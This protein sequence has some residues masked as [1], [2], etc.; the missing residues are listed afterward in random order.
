MISNQS[1]SSNYHRR[2]I[3]HIFCSDTK[4]TR[5]KVAVVGSEVC[6]FVFVSYLGACRDAR[7]W[8]P[9]GMW[10]AKL[11]CACTRHRSLAC[12]TINWNI[13]RQHFIV[14]DA[15]FFFYFRG[16]FS[17]LAFDNEFV[18]GMSGINDWERCVCLCGVCV[19][20]WSS[21][22]EWYST[23]TYICARCVWMWMHDLVCYCILGWIELRTK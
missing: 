1:G 3:V 15:F 11:V 5:F 18:W 7:Y 22:C 10:N 20:L 16:L 13:G 19:E 4:C 8:S 2:L 21:S 12:T 6:Y 9:S 17:I 23:I 14:L